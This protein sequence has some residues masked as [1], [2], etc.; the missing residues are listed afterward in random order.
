MQRHSEGMPLCVLLGQHDVF[1]HDVKLAHLYDG[2]PYDHLPSA[3]KSSR[4]LVLSSVALVYVDTR[5]QSLVDWARSHYQRIGLAVTDCVATFSGWS[6]LRD[7]EHP[8]LFCASDEAYE[9][10]KSKSTQ[11][12]LAAAKKWNNKN[13][14]I[15]FCRATGIPVPQTRCSNTDL[16]FWDSVVYPVVCKAAVSAGGHDVVKCWFSYQLDAARK[17]LGGREY[18]LQELL[19]D[20]T[21]YF[22]AQYWA[23]GGRIRRIGVTEQHLT[24]STYDGA[25]YPAD[26]DEASLWRICEPLAQ[27]V[28]ADGFEGPFNIDVAFVPGRG[29]L[30][31]EVNPRWSA[32][33]YALA[34]VSRL[35][36]EVLQAP[37][38][39]W[40][41]CEV[42]VGVGD[43]AEL[44]IA[45][46]EFSA[47]TGEGILL[48]D[49]GSIVD[50][51]PFVTVLVV[52]P[53]RRQEELL[54]VFRRRARSP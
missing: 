26:V 49:W 22:G 41:Y 10:R 1:G 34:A 16:G 47:K 7:S 13:N 53:P 54:G 39:A 38:P 29:F 11:R 20:S 27:A 42:R 28:A 36:H 2:C 51:R 14:V 23:I 9:R 44:D 4:A 17:L 24:G 25:V 31:M 37:I 48:V 6:V 50:E 5:L 30:V 3:G 33:T 18:Q 46:L 12:W 45:D 32:T 35:E 43:Y 52:G 15:R 21:R 19:P 40:R 8:S